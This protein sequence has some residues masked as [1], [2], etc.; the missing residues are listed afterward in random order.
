MYSSKCI[1]KYQTVI[2]TGGLGFI[3]G[4]LIRKLLQETNPNFNESK[5]S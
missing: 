3:G 5:Y 2:I 4:C 1:F